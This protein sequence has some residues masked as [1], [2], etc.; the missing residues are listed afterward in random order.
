MK[1]FVDTTLMTSFQ[2]HFFTISY[3]IITFLMAYILN[4]FYE[5]PMMNLRDRI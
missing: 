5:K 1:Y 4:R 2:R 3:L